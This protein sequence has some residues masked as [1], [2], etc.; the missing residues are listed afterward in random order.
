MPKPDDS[1]TMATIEPDRYRLIA[2]R[3][4]HR[5]YDEAEPSA[6]IATAVL[7][8]LRDLDQGPSLPH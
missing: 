4:D 5:F 3:L 6:R 7:A 2:E 1:H 8:A